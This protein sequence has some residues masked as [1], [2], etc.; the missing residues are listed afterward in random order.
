MPF[1]SYR[2]SG[3]RREEQDFLEEWEGRVVH[4]YVKGKIISV[5]TLPGMGKW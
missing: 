5:E 1:F 3:N 4:M 2:K